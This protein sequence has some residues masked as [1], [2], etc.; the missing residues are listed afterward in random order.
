MLWISLTFFLSVSGCAED[1][2]Y[3][4]A[5]QFLGPMPGQTYVYRVSG[6]GTMHVTGVSRYDN[7]VLVEEAVELTELDPAAFPAPS[8]TRYEIYALEDQLIRKRDGKEQVLIR[9]PLREKGSSWYI[10]G[11]ILKN[12]A[13]EKIRSECEVETVSSEHILGKDRGLVVVLC[14]TQLVAGQETVRTTHAEDL[15]ILRVWHGFSDAT[16]KETF[17]GESLT[18]VEIR[19]GEK[20]E[21]IKTKQ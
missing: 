3:L 19:E 15:G 2:E 12:G 8:P 17:E 18:L 11:V 5:H 4:E 13:A 9:E 16:S 10:D 7:G 14:V 6:I 20:V 21:T 1:L